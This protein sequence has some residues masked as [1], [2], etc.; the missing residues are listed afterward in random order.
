MASPVPQ[1]NID[2]FQLPKG[3][4]FKKL[5]YILAFVGPASMICSTS[6]GP[7]TASSCIQA[8]SM[9]GYDLLWVVVLS[10]IM[11]GGV[12]YIGAKTT[13]LSGMN[14]FDFIKSKIGK[15]ATNILF[16]VV[17]CTWMM[18]IY[19]QGA[20]MKHLNDLLFGTTLSPFTFGITL[21]I[22]AYLYVSSSNN[23]IIKIAS[24]MCTIMAVIFFINVFF[25]KPDFTQLAAG[26]IPGLPNKEQAIIIAGVIGGSAPGTSAF[27]YSYSVKNQKWDKPSAL[28][29]IKW[30]QV[31]FA[32]MFTIF[33]LG[34]FLSGAAVLNPAGVQV[35]SALDAAKA[36]EPLAGAAGKYIFLLGFWGAV[37][38]TIGGMSTLASYGINSICNIS[39]NNSDIKVRRV[40]LVGIVL[41]LLGG[42]SGGNA[43]SLLVNFMGLL[44]IG[45][46]VIIC[47]LTYYTS[48]KKFA[49]EYVNKWYTTLMG[50]VILGFNV[51]SAWTYIARFL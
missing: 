9:F 50:V 46:L 7:G 17:L 38:T 25:V 47:I 14:V 32:L 45:G 36:I 33:S 40:I 23:R 39:S 43:M 8:G 1:K 42:L 19:S 24:V 12:A 34:I 2:E 11:C 44:N 15:I 20:T 37:F 28:S 6:M 22:I 16:V 5:A 41:S 18:V 31:I 26:M 10:G 29:F 35:T 30:D 27:W 13:A 49:G 21:A 4:V 3:N 51:Y 48:R